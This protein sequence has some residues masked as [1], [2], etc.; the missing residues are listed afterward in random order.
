MAELTPEQKENIDFAMAAFDKLA[1][2]ALLCDK[3]HDHVIAELTKIID[4]NPND[5]SAYVDRGDMH[6]KKSEYDLAMS[7]FNKALELKPD[8]EEAFYKRGNVYNDKGEYDLAIV[9]LTKAI[10]LKPDTSYFY[11]NRG[12]AYNGKGEYDMAIA[13]YTYAMKLSPSF[14]SA[15]VDR[16]KTY[17]QL[18]DY[19]SAIADFEMALMLRSDNNDFSELLEKAKA[20]KIQSNQNEIPQP[21]KSNYMDK[22]EFIEKFKSLLEDIVNRTQKAMREGLLSLEEDLNREKVKEFDIFEYGLCFIIDR[23]DREIV[24]NI[25]SHII[26][27]ESDK[28]THK[29]KSLQKEAV[30]MIQSGIDARSI[31][32]TLNSYIDLP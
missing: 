31:C 8:F 14:I 15:Y 3:D 11:Y 4:K 9:E 13:E 26:N 18:K 2:M 25:L 19:T 29:F 20:D 22:T 32:E 10:E 6:H 23:V 16:G 27:Q 5:A 1:R 28:L 7:D 17:N 21:K 30:L 12:I 24:N